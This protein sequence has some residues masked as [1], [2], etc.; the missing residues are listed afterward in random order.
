[1]FSGGIP[2]IDATGFRG[3]CLI[4][5][6]RE[7]FDVRFILQFKTDIDAVC[8]SPNKKT[9][10]ESYDYRMYH[11]MALTFNAFEV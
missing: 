11:K 5:D 7:Y 1:M 10:Y 8:Q 4:K 3:S 6:Y 9:P 2:R